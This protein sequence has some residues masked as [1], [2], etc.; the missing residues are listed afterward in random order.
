MTLTAPSTRQT[1][2]HGASRGLR[3]STR[4]SR[5]N[6]QAALGS[7]A[8]MRQPYAAWLSRLPAEV[9]HGLQ[10][11]PLEAVQQVARAMFAQP[12]SLSKMLPSTGVARSC[13]R[14]QNYGD[15]GRR[16]ACAASAASCAACR[17]DSA[18]VNDACS[19]GRSSVAAA[20]S[21][22]ESGVVTGL[23]LMREAN[24]SAKAASGHLRPGRHGSARPA[25]VRRVRRA[26]TAAM[27]GA[28]A[29][30][31]RVRRLQG[32]GPERFRPRRIRV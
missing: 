7:R 6:W 24:V 10:Q 11:L 21:L 30:S 25:T 31:R 22:H 12:A 29:A 15:N 13:M 28:A 18:S 3:S 2:A 19:H 9:Q 14:L 5:R 27:P 26:S 1:I 20:R 32:H 4:A 23:V 17:P 8:D 16:L